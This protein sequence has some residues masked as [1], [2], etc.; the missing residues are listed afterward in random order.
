M[1]TSRK[2]LSPLIAAVLLIVVVV[3]IGAVV[4]GIVRSQV[5]ADKQTIEKKSVD[6][7]C[8]TLV[9]IDVPTLNDD[10]MICTG[11]GYVNFTLENSG[12]I[13]VDEIQIKVF[14]D[15]GFADNDSLLTTGL[16]PGAVESQFIAAFNIADVGNV[17]EV[18]IIPKKK[19]VGG[20]SRIFCSEAQLRF[21]DISPC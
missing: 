7:D 4:T 14:G 17:E 10:F 19:V 9:E 13:L 16:E 11:T 5:T 15:A 1:L 2:A 8:S 12:T 18:F 6:I 21:T 20:N 3:G